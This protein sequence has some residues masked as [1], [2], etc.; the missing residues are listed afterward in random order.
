MHEFERG[1]II[2][3]LQKYMKRSVFVFVLVSA[4]MMF[5][6]SGCSNKKPE[7]SDSLALDSSMSDS[8]ADDTLESIISETPMPKSADELFDDFIFNF[9]AN[10]KLQLKR[11]TFPIIVTKFGKTETLNK[12]QWKMEHFFM[13]QGYYTLIFDNVKQMNLVKDTTIDHVIIEKVYFANNTVKQYFFNRV[14]GLWMLQ[15]INYKLISQTQNASFLAFYNR[16]ANDTAFQKRSLANPVTFTGADPDD[17][18][19]KLTGTF[20]PEQWPTFAPQLPKGFIYNILYGQKYTQSN[21][22]IFV[23]RGISNGLETELIF[24]RKGGRWKLVRLNT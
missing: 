1:D 20:D 9:A 21:Q 6:S 7:A 14:Q 16:F 10:R 4:F 18:F 13:R 8:S 22:K 2:I 12:G 17:D 5:W 11:I 19:S 23:L 24:K 3:Q 15:G